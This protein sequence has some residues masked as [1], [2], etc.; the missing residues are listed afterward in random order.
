MSESLTQGNYIQETENK[1]AKYLGAKYAVVVSSATAGLHISYLAL[2]VNKKNKILTTPNTFVS[3]SNAALYCDSKPIF[4]DISI[5]N[6]NLSL[7]K[8]EKNIE[9]YKNLR[10]IV[11][12]HVGKGVWHQI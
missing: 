8:L 6:L 11:P 10:T 5:D 12:V 7:N 4:S 9:K 1:I 2:N 3:T